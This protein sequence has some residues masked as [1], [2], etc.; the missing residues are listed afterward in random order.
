M[1]DPELIESNIFFCS[2]RP[3]EDKEVRIGVVRC[4]SLPKRKSYPFYK[5]FLNHLSNKIQ[6]KL[7]I[8]N[9]YGGASINISLTPLKGKNISNIDVKNG[10]LLQLAKLFSSLDLIIGN[11]TGLTHLSAFANCNKNAFTIGLYNRHSYFKWNTGFQNH[12][13]IGT[14]FSHHMG[15]KDF[16]PVRDNIDERK[17]PLLCNFK[18]INPI[19]LSQLCLNLL[20]Q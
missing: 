16:C 1:Y 4:S 6:R 11:D 2:E 14:P 20:E 3:S 13:C 19:Y 9:F 8:Y 5:T 17:Y 12:L 18:N 15:I 7:L 10:T